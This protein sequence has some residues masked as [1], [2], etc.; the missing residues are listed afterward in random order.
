MT[1]HLEA[2]HGRALIGW[3]DRLAPTI[4]ELGWLF[5]V[6]NGLKLGGTGSTPQDRRIAAM[7]AALA[8]AEGLRSGVWDYHLPFR[9]ACGAHPSL[10]VEL[11]RPE[12]EHA[13]D[14]GLSDDQ[15]RFG[16]AVAGQ[17]ARVA[18]CFRWTE[19]AAVIL[20]HLRNPHAEPRGLAPF[21]DVDVGQIVLVRTPHLL[22]YQPVR[23]TQKT[24]TAR[25]KRT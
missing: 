10:W 3:A 18:V 21:A 4:P 17:G 15:R 25:R 9:S 23:R 5:H 22:A 12:H 13:A 7:R 11:K 16:N 19:A 20:N 8:K 2:Q 24:I 1:R 6:P 14:G